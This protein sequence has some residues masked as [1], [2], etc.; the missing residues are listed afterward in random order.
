M[1]KWKFLVFLCL[2]AV[3]SYSQPNDKTEKIGLSKYVKP[4]ILIGGFFN[5]K[6]EYVYI[7]QQ[8]AHVT[9]TR[10]NKGGGAIS[11]ALIFPLDK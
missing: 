1:K 8:D 2:A 7:L 3:Q 6:G 9:E 4:G 10:D 11:L 5:P